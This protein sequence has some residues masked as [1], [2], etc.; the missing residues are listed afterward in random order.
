MR[1][2]DAEIREFDLESDAEA[3]MQD[4]QCFVV[5]YADGAVSVVP[6]SIIMTVA[7]ANKGVY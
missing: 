7:K 4:G 1:G 5:S 6:R 3:W 2:P